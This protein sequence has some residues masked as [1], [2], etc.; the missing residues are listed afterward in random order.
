LYFIN[1][2]RVVGIPTHLQTAARQKNGKSR[3]QQAQKKNASSLVAVR[4]GSN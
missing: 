2:A 1:G 3:L 4:L